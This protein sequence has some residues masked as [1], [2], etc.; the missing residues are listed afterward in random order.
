MNWVWAVGC[1]GYG[2]TTGTLITNMLWKRAMR[3]RW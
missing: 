2:V 1:F 3:S